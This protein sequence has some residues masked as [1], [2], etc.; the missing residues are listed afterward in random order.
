MS[1]KLLIEPIYDSLNSTD[2]S[3]KL[4]A[5][6]GP[7]V[8]F[9]I[10]NR[11][12]KGELRLETHLVGVEASGTYDPKSKDIVFS[13]ERVAVQPFVVNNFAARR[14]RGTEF[15]CLENRQ[16]ADNSQSSMPVISSEVMDVFESVF[17]PTIRVID[18]L[19][20][21]ARLYRSHPV[22]E[23]LREWESVETVLVS[24]LGLPLGSE[25]EIQTTHAL[26]IGGKLG[27]LRVGDCVP[28]Q[29]IQSRSEL[30]RE[31]TEFE[32]KLIVSDSSDGLRAEI[33]QEFP[34]P[35]MFIVT[36]DGSRSFSLKQGS[37]FRLENLSVQARS[38]QPAPTIYEPQTHRRK[39]TKIG[40]PSILL[41][42]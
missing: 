13:V 9:D 6:V 39:H 25:G 32:R 34:P 17:Q 1:R 12:G 19:I 29:S 35:G 4:N 36:N 3:V 33:D 8:R 41:P 11:Y 26:C 23:I 16:H 10:F 37:P 30:I 31:L 27:A 22:N 18:R 42:K 20:S 40:Q 38:L 14:F 7:L 21:R 15:D 2:K 24:V 28:N 5:D